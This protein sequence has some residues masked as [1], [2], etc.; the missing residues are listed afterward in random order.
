[1][2]WSDF[3]SFINFQQAVRAIAFS[4][5]LFCF[6]TTAL[7]YQFLLKTHLPTARV[8]KGKLS[9]QKCTEFLEVIY[10]ELLSVHFYSRPRIIP[11]YCPWTICTGKSTELLAS[12]PV[13]S[14]TPLLL[15]GFFLSQQ[16]SYKVCKDFFI[17]TLHFC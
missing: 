4:K 2:W 6:C 5:L 9:F 14:I 16:H 13:T 10:L 8:L 3:L 11:T 12:L 17:G 15:I 7:F 1:M